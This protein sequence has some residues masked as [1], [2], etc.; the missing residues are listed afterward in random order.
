M[1]LKRL[2]TGVNTK[3]T[4]FPEKDFNFSDTQNLSLCIEVGFRHFTASLINENTFS[5]HYAEHIKFE[6]LNELENKTL[7]IAKSHLGTSFNIKK[8]VGFIQWK[9]ANTEKK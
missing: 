7:D 2:V 8:S 5:V 4:F 1:R 3:N 9:Q 6:T